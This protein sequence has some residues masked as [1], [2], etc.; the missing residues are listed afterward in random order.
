M[1]DV[2]VSRRL[3]RLGHETHG[4]GGLLLFSCL[5]FPLLVLTITAAEAEEVVVGRDADGRL[6]IQATRY[7]GVV[8]LDGVLDESIYQSILPITDFVQQIPDEG[9]A[10]SE[11]T[12]AWVY[13][14]DDNLYIAARNYESVPESEWVANE[15]RRDTFQLRSNDSFSV[16][17]DTFLDRRNGVAFLVTPIGGFSDFAITN[18]GGGGR[19]VNI[20][21]NIV[22]DSWIG[23][24]TRREHRPDRLHPYIELPVLFGIQ[25]PADSMGVGQSRCR[26]PFVRCAMSRALSR[27]GGYNFGVLSAA[28][29]RHHTLP[30]YRSPPPVAIV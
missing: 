13:F 26:F 14:D 16:M 25:G 1:L 20:D 24:S 5:I 15:M 2:F 4:N 22:W 19:S 30:R 9:A 27:L 3:K 6:T 8:D 7:T 18:E 10:A 12:E 28:T 11:K 23:R 17:L 21:W 29:T